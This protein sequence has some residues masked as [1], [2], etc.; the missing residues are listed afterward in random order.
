MFE[1][2][3]ADHGGVERTV[4][5]W[6]IGHSKSGVL[7]G[8]EGAGGEKHGGPNN[9]EQSEPVYTWMIG[10]FHGFRAPILKM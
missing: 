8:H 6:P 1:G 2:D 7:G 4:R 10:G 3:A 5:K 9:N